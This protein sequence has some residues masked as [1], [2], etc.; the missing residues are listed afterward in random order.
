[1]CEWLV[2]KR[3]DPFK[4]RTIEIMNKLHEWGEDTCRVLLERIIKNGLSVERVR[5]SNGDPWAIGEKV[6]TVKG[7]TFRWIYGTPRRGA[8]YIWFRNGHVIKTK[9]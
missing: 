9:G 4:P 7:K 2:E 8:T 3:I 1:M 6:V 5:L